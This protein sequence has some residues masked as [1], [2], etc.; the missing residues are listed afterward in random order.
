MAV[1][2]IYLSGLW[3]EWLHTAAKTHELYTDF[4]PDAMLPDLA[5]SGA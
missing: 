2:W 3:E 5:R 4:K 1:R